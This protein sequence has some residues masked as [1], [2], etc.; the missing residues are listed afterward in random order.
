MKRNDVFPDIITSFPEADI[1]LEGL[2]AWLAQG[3]DF[4]V[5]FLTFEKE[6]HVPEHTHDE[7]WEIVLEGMVD[8]TMNGKISRYQKG[9]RFF[10]SAGV[11]HSA[12]VHEG[13]CSIAIFFQ[14]DRYSMK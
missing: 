1:P 9:D 14:P 11:P 2:T 6:T 7:Q 12:L 8:V 4:Q 3:T 5:V 13:F 10:V